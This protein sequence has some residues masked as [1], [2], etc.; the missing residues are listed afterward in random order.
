MKVSIIEDFVMQRYVLLYRDEDGIWI[1]EVP[2]L[3]GCISHG[4]S[5]E[6]AL[7]N[8]QEAIELYLTVIEED[9][10]EIPEEFLEPEIVQITVKRTEAHG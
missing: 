10:L 9:N 4:E 6:A 3:Q 1:A 7:A 5:R 8:I 2:S